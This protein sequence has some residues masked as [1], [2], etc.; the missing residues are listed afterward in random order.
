MAYDWF[1]N[2]DAVLDSMD[3]RCTTG[4]SP[5]ADT[6]EDWE[7]ECEHIGVHTQGECEECNLANEQQEEEE[8]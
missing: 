1:P 6:L 5:Y 2:E 3:R 8:A 4:N 7:E